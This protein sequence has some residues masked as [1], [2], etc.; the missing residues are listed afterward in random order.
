MLEQ[1]SVPLTVLRPWLP[2]TCLVLRDIW[3]YRTSRVLYPCGTLNSCKSSLTCDLTSP[4]TSCRASGVLVVGT[5]SGLM[6]LYQMPGFEVLHALSVSRERVTSVAFNKTGDWVAGACVCRK[7]Q[8][9]RTGPFP[10][11]ICL[12]WL[13]AWW[14]ACCF[15]GILSFTSGTLM[16]DKYDSVWH[17]SAP[18]QL[19]VCLLH[20]TVLACSAV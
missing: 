4:R 18:N 7:Q 16:S 14:C 15:W 9:A 19:L 3:C 11:C 1:R 12:L 13:A 20:C 5:S 2:R 6:D 8:D 10:G 17:D